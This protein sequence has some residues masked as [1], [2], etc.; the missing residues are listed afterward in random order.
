MELLAE[1][2]TEAPRDPEK[3]RQ[4]PQVARRH[5]D[6]ETSTMATP[7]KLCP[8]SG[9]FLFPQHPTSAHLVT[10][11]WA[12]SQPL[13]MDPPALPQGRGLLHPTPDT[14]PHFL[15]TDLGSASPQKGSPGNPAVRQSRPSTLLQS[16]VG[17]KSMGSGS[18]TSTRQQQHQRTGWGKEEEPCVW[19]L[20]VTVKFPAPTFEE[21]EEP[22]LRWELRLILLI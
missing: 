6:R 18:W 19:T 3:T 5:V 13:L 10:L 20:Y 14:G 7:R 9:P 11:S 12:E 16:S 8:I 21:I 4:G 22:E 17:W 1:H 2:S 15:C